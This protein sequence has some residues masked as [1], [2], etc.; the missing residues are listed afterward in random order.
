MNLI[1]EFSFCRER[2]TLVAD[3]ALQN[4]R[5]FQLQILEGKRRRVLGTLI[6]NYQYVIIEIFKCGNF[7]ATELI[8]VIWI[9][10]YTYNIYTYNSAIFFSDMNSS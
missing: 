10:R 3:T 6:S 5:A 7:L 9:L 4:H 2:E 8:G 1:T